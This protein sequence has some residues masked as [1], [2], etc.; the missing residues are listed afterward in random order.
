M[1]VWVIMKKPL[2]ILT[3]IAIIL[4][5]N[6]CKG[7]DTKKEPEQIR[8]HKERIMAYMPLEFNFKRIYLNKVSMKRLTRGKK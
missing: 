5:F 3:L 8:W 2:I 1:S 6:A 7:A 4:S